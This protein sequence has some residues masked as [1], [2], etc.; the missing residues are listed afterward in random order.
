MN[1]HEIKEFLYTEEG[2]LIVALIVGAIIGAERE[3]RS[4]AAGFRTVILVTVG[5]CL[6]TILSI[7]LGGAG[8]KARIAAN[9]VTGIGFLGAGAIYRDKISIRG[10]TTATTIWISAAIGMAIGC[11]Q[12]SLTVWVTSIAMIILLSFSWFQRII[13]TVNQEKT[14]K[15]TYGEEQM[16]QITVIENLFHSYRLECF[17]VKQIKHKDEIVIV[18]TANGKER[19]HGLFL[20]DLYLQTQIKAFEV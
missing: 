3:Y 2:K 1:I 17:R 20:N 8:D 5:A 4:K 14:Y 16:D 15:I 7:Q 6:F 12:F 10:I 11:S 13:D 19:N 9:I 18:Y